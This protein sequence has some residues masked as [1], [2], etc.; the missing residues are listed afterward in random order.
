MSLR[1]VTH[2]VSDGLL[3]FATATGDGLHIKVGVS[4]IVSNTPIIVTG[5]MDAAKIKSRL[6]LSPLTDSVMDAV[7]FGAGRIF[8]IPVAATTKGTIGEITHEGEGVGTVAV[9]GEPTNAFGVIVKITGQGGFNTAAFAVSIDDGYSFSDEITVPLTGTYEIAGTGL[10]LT[11]TEAEGE[12]QKASSFIVNDTFSCKTTAPVATNGDILT[13][14]EK[15]KK[16]TQEFEFIHIVGESTLPLWQAMSEF[17][18]ELMTEHKKPAFILLEAAM[19]TA[20]EDGSLDDW[21]F[22]MEEDRKK[23]KNTDIQVCAAWGLLVRL[24]GTTQSVNLAGAASGRYAMTSVQKSIGQTRPEAG[25]GFPKTKL[26]ELL[27]A[28][29]DSVIIKMLDEAGYMTFREYDGLDDFFVYHTKMMSPDGSDFRYAEDVRVKNKII[30]E[31]RKE[32]LLLKNDDIDLD[33]VQG[34]LE[35]RAKFISTPLD[36]MVED[37][38]ISS[39]ET[40]VVE[41]HEETFLEDETLRV[42]IRYLSRGYIRE[43]EVDLGRASLND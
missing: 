4:P 29:Y 16:F 43:V 32:A 34:E 41:G 7:Q 38:E 9:T 22:Q 27:P 42:K 11:F 10:K 6:G 19:P 5:D 24:D 15:I 33:N 12:D 23:I 35:T 25:M 20:A 18:I 26:L 37:K 8:C 36:R 17:Q 21:A 28:A 39:Y 31:T 1:D 14:V 13:A 30:R 2:K 3:G 40:T